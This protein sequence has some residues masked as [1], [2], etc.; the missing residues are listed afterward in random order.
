MRGGENLPILPGE[1][2]GS[3]ESLPLPVSPGNRD[4]VRVLEPY[5]NPGDPRLALLETGAGFA[6]CR[7]VSVGVHL[8]P[9]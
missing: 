7:Q 5:P 6:G 2:R 1:G 8:R 4:M 3:V 9:L